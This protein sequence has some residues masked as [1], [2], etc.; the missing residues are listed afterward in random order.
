MAIRA[1]RPERPP[2]MV[3]ELATAPVLN[4]TAEGIR[5]QIGSYLDYM[6]KAGKTPEHIHL[7]GNQYNTLHKAFSERLDKF[8][9]PLAGMTFSGIP[10][11]R[12]GRGSASDAS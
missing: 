10:V 3:Y 8:A 5:R 2:P 9:P 1:A 4:K 7:H 12:L 6:A 11:V